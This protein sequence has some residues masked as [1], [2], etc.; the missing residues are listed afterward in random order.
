MDRI[1][2]VTEL[3]RKFRVVFANVVDNHTPYIIMANSKP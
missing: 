1:I 2:G 3:R